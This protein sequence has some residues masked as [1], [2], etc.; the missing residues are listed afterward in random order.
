MQQVFSAAKKS[1]FWENLGRLSN[2]LH[3]VP[4]I[5]LANGQNLFREQPLIENKKWMMV[6]PWRAMTAIFSFFISLL[7]MYPTTRI[8]I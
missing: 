6:K 5:H 7:I 2:V 8:Y 3:D 4:M 1:S